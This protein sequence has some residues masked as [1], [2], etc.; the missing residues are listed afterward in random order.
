MKK[1]R[2]R[3]RLKKKLQK[4]NKFEEREEI[5]QRNK[6]LNTKRILKR[7]KWRKINKIRI[8]LVYDGEAD[9]YLGRGGG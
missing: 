3:R 2:T 4:V 8:N 5:G 9:R 7:E 6:Q 1:E